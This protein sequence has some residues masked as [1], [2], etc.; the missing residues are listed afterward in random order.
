MITNSII[1]NSSNSV[2][3]IKPILKWA[4]GKGQLLEQIAKHLPQELIEGK[5]DCYIEPFI[6]GGAVFF[7]VAQNFNIREFYL[8]DINQELILLYKTIQKDV[9]SLIEELKKIENEYLILN[10]EKRKIYFFNKRNSYNDFKNQIDLKNFER[11]WFTRSAEIIFLNRTCFNGLFRVNKKGSFNVPF[12]NYK[13]PRICNTNN[14]LLASKLLQKATIQYSDFTQI[15]N[16]ATPK[17]FV[18]FDPPYRPLTKTASFKSYSQFDFND[19]EQK[20]LASFY[21]K[22]D[23]QGT[24]LM[25]SNSDPKNIDKNDNFFDELYSDFTINRIQANRMINSKTSRRGAISE[26]LITNY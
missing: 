25:L 21:Q 2:N 5:I 4:G 22:L 14:L 15:Q 9:N 26:L 18:Y 10:E 11:S 8:S 17:T 19:D 3:V 24:K 13:N 1:C 20:R 12:G 23:H 6:G 7:W 16:L